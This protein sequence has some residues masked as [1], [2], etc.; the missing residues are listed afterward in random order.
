MFYQGHDQAG[1][2]VSL[3]KVP[4]RIVC[5]V[6]SLT[7]LLFDLGLG[8]KV[9]GVTRFCVKPSGARKQAA[10]VGGTK[11]IDVKTVESLKPDLIIGNKEEN[12]KEQINEIKNTTPVWLSEISN[13]QE[14]CS[15]IEQLGHLTD[16][17][18]RASLLNDQI[19]SAVKKLRQIP[20]THKS[21]LYFIWKKPY[22]V[23]GRSTYINSILDLCGLKNIAPDSE[24]RYPQLSIDYIQKLQPQIIL[25]S[26]EPY[27]F[28]SGDL[29]Q[30]TQK[31]DK[32]EGFLL[33]GEIFSWYGS[34]LIP[35]LDSI[36]YFKMKLNKNSL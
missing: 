3:K 18:S 35:A 29:H 24:S 13:V 17:Q 34:R 36:R 9:V 25:L 4:E 23:A 14:A 22:M 1:F 8:E 2:E 7:E 19:Q 31:Q 12:R 11:D 16:T 6:P 26:S 32:A 5:T 28:S 10:I 27:P 30:I 33:N 21:V 15:A 20:D